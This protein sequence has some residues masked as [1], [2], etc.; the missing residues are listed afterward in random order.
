MGF[1]TGKIWKIKRTIKRYPTIDG[2]MQS[3]EN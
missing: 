3:M 1:A 2:I